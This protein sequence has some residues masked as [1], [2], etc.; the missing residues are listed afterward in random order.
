M[1]ILQRLRAVLPQQ[2]RVLAKITAPKGTGA[3]Q[4]Q[5]ASGDGHLILYGTG[6]TVGQ[7]VF[8]DMD[9]LRILEVAPDLKVVTIRV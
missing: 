5:T 2:R 6:Y 3:Y 1:N 7:Q 9:T 4:A 8:Y